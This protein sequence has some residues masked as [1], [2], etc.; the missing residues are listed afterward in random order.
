MSLLNIK[1]SVKIQQTALSRKNRRTMAKLKREDK[2]L[3]KRD[4]RL[5]VEVNRWML[6]R[7][8]KNRGRTV[9]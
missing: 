4:P 8:L 6:R 9:G 7:L 2:L 1:K 3:M 5:L